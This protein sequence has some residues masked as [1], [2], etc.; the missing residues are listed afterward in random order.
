MSARS[1]HRHSQFFSILIFPAVIQAR[2]AGMHRMRRVKWGSYPLHNRVIWLRTRLTL[3]IHEP[4][5][6][7]PVHSNQPYGSRFTTKP[8]LAKHSSNTSRRT[9]VH[10]CK[11]S[12]PNKTNQH[13]SIAMKQYHAQIRHGIV[14]RFIDNLYKCD[15]SILISSRKVTQIL[16]QQNLFIAF[17][18]IQDVEKR[19]RNLSVCN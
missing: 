19:A 12:H 14:L 3:Y 10:R 1:R 13:S 6:P 11:N 8:L 7:R 16:F 2:R 9:T 5:C 4:P 17:G 18:N 15:V